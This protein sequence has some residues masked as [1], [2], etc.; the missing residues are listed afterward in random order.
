[1]PETRASGNLLAS[2]EEFASGI[3]SLASCAST[4][5]RP[6]RQ[7]LMIVNMTSP[8]TNGNQAPVGI[9]IEFEPNSARSMVM[10]GTSTIPITGQRQR[11]MPRITAAARTV[12]S[13]I[14]PV[15][16]KPYAEARALELPK[17][18]TSAST[19]ASNSQL[20]CGM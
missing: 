8:I 5:R 6:V 16:A 20:T 9:F 2:G 14:V 18:T 3:V 15:T 11:Q 19:A 12:V 10:I 1:M 13:A 7:V 4:N 17:L